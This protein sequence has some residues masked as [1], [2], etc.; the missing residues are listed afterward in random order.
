MIKAADERDE[1]SGADRSSRRPRPMSV[2][3]MSADSARRADWARFFEEQGLRAIRCAGPRA[4]TCALEMGKN[5]PLHQE[6]DLIF[7]DEESVTRQLEDELDLCSLTV[8]VAYASTMEQ[9]DGRQFPVP[10]RVRPATRR[11]PSSR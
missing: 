4:T 11:N 1:R 3:V 6:A 2:L 5:C 10:E 9:P 7:Y 8:P